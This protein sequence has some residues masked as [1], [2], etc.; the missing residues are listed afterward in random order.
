MTDQSA[1]VPARTRFRL[2]LSLVALFGWVVIPAAAPAP[3][4]PQSGLVGV[5]AD[6]PAWG[7]ML[8]ALFVLAVVLICRWRDVGLRPPV[9]WRSLRLLWLPALYPLFFVAAAVAVGLPPLYQIGLIVLNTAFVALSEELM[10]RGILF[11]GL[12]TRM[13]LV[14]AIVVTTLIFGGAHLLNLPVV[15]AFWPTLAQA[16]A[17]CMTGLLFLALRIRTRSLYPVIALHAV[18]NAAA[19]LAASGA[20]TRTGAA[21]GT[22]P[23]LPDQPLVLLAPLL[24]ALPNFLYALYLLRRSARPEPPT[25]ETAQPASQAS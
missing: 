9:N 13:K 7:I 18:W 15:G 12:R 20:L 24:V 8:A 1:D 14:P 6:R 16:V 17:A 25:I 10:F 4:D 2:T 5:I 23:A 21:G 22:A 3:A 11:S 19:L